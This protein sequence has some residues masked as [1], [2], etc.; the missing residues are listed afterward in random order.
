MAPDSDKFSSESSANSD[1]PQ[2][3]LAPAAAGGQV[4][5]SPLQPHVASVAAQIAE[6]VEAWLVRS[7][8]KSTRENYAMDLVQFLDFI[9]APVD[10]LDRLATVRPVM[11]A[12][13]R[14]HLREAGLTNSSIRWEMTALRSLFSYLQTYTYL[15]AA[16][17]L[18]DPE[19][20][21][22]GHLGYE[23]QVVPAEAGGLLPRAVGLIDPDDGDVV[24]YTALLQVVAPNGRLDAAQA[25]FVNRSL[26]HT[27]PRLPGVNG[28]TVHAPLPLAHAKS[29]ASTRLKGRREDASQE[30]A[31][32]LSAA[33]QKLRPLDP[34]ARP[35]ASTPPRETQTRS[36]GE[37]LVTL[38]RSD[39][40][41]KT[42]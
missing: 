38:V 1:G 10:G 15:G 26:R 19:M 5:S 11:V 22:V 33:N 17:P 31:G 16:R 4:V 37:E 41:F 32:A 25:N 34:A 27:A 12:A 2:H 30:G 35:D 23:R 42:L 40:L 28:K 13:W 9:G 8:S 36:R 18:V 14:G 24:P 20:G 7:N 39:L 3:A 29:S 21:Q 6:A